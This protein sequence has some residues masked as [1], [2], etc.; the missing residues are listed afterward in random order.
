[1]PLRVGDSYIDYM[2][3]VPNLLNKVQN[4]CS[5]SFVGGMGGVLKDLVWGFRKKDGLLL[6]TGGN[7]GNKMDARLKMSGMT[8]GRK[9]D[10]R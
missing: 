3:N 10:P 1:M 2:K 8:A 9:M 7:E 5:F 6:T 4:Y